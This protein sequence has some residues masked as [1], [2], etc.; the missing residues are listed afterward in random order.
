MAPGH[1]PTVSVVSLEVNY[2]WIPITLHKLH[3]QNTNFSHK[4]SICA[5]LNPKHAPPTPFPQQSPLDTTVTDLCALSV[6]SSSRSSRRA[7]WAIS[8][9]LQGRDLRCRISKPRQNLLPI[10]SSS[11]VPS[12]RPWWREAQGFIIPTY[13]SFPYRIICKLINSPWSTEAILK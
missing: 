9:L 1:G 12:C 13:G 3:F 5:D 4:E 6:I 2:I 7:A 10:S 8:S 11:C